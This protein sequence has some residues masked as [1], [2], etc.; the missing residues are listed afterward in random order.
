MELSV[1]GKSIEIVGY[2]L[3]EIQRP[4]LVCQL[5]LALKVLPVKGRI[6]AL[7]DA[8]LPTT[9]NMFLAWQKG[10]CRCDYSMD[11]E[12]GRLS[13]LVQLG[14]IKSEEL[15]KVEISSR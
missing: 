4:Y 14:P 3:L 6:M 5:F 11:L 13:W 10:L 12:M 15:L 2:L 1:W 7:K 9:C 8:Q